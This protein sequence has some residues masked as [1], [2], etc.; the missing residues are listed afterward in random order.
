[1]YKRQ[2]ECWPRMRLILSRWAKEGA[3]LRGL[4]LFK[5]NNGGR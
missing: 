2:G 1:V 3:T 5:H 4:L